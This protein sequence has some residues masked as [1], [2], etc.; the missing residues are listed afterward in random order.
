MELVLMTRSYSQLQERIPI[1]LTKLISC[2]VCDKMYILELPYNMLRGQ[3]ITF[4][5]ITCIEII[6]SLSG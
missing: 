3:G 2:Y 1:F 4:V 6:K 5:G